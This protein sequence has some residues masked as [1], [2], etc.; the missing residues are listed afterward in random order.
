MRGFM[1]DTPPDRALPIGMARA[2]LR[3]AP[4]SIAGTLRPCLCRSHVP[5]S[6]GSLRN[7]VSGSCGQLRKCSWIFGTDELDPKAANK[8]HLT[9]AGTDW[10]RAGSR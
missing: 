7:G 4:A 9:A 3:I 1:L 5:E 8:I 10:L 2:A 6:A